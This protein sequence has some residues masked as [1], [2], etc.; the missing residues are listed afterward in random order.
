MSKYYI[1]IDKNNIIND[2]ISY[3]KEWFIEIELEQIP[4][5]FISGAYSYVN[6]QP[7][8]NQTVVDKIK[9]DELLVNNINNNEEN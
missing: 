6:W 5:Y 1:K 9:Q 3:Q 7:F 8:L 2:I 4:E